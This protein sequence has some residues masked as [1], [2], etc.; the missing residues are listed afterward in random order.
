M[1][2]CCAGQVDS[3]PASLLQ[4]PLRAQTHIPKLSD[5]DDQSPQ[6]LSLPSSVYGLPTIPLLVFV[7]WFVSFSFFIFPC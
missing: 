1:H 7:W 5:L 2:R 4:A 6:I 3:I